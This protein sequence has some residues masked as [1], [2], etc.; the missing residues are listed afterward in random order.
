MQTIDR[1]EARRKLSSDDRIVLI[2][3]P[4]VVS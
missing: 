3:A 4:P 1:H 2:D